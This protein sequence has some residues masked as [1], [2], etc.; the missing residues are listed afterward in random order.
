MVRKLLENSLLFLKVLLVVSVLVYMPYSTVTLNNTQVS[1]V[2][3][4]N[5]LYQIY[6]AQAELYSEATQ[7]DLLL[8]QYTKKVEVE[9]LDRDTKQVKNIGVI[10][11]YLNKPDYSYLR[12]ITVLIINQSK[13]NPDQGSLGTGVVIKEEEKST[14]IVT[15]KHVCPGDDDSRCYV[16]DIDTK[17]EYPISI[18]KQSSTHDVQI[19][20][21]DGKLPRKIPVKGIKDIEPQDRV[22]MVGHNLGNPFMYSEG[23]V[24]GFERSSKNLIVTMPSGPGNS[25]SG[26]IT[27]DGYLSGLLYS[28]KIVGQFPYMSLDLTHG[29]CV[30]SKVLK[31]FLR[32]YLQ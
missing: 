25:G 30:N 21:I 31:L 7:L 11:K 20:K 22:Y 8:L 2:A 27:Q 1:V 5:T 18:V 24:A 12:N 17:L 16:L 32:D 9:S 10:A 13:E 15:N 29:I 26:I 23:V 6:Q 3:L 28:G 4:E 19:V 14:Y